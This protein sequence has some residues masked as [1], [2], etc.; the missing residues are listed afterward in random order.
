MNTSRLTG[1]AV[2]ALSLT[3][4]VRT[5]APTVYGLDSAELAAGAYT[6][7]IV[8]SP[9][10]PLFLLIGKLFCFLPWGDVG[11][12]VNLWSAVSAALGVALVYGLAFRLTRKPWISAACALMLAFSYY[13][14]VWALVAE[15]YAPHVLFTAGVLLCLFQWRDTRK[16]AWLWASAA[17]WG[18]GMGNHTALILAAPGMAWLA[19]DN[20]G[21]AW[22]RPRVWGPAVL[23]APAVMFAVY[24]YLP[25]RYAAEPALDYVRAYY[26]DIRLDRPGGFFWMLR[27]GMFSSLFFRRPVWEIAQSAGSFA[28]QIIGNFGFVPACFAGYGAVCM[29]HS[30]TLRAA[31]RGL[32]LIFAVHAF[33][34]W[35]YGAL[36][37]KW[38]YSVC[39]AIWALF[40]AVGWS[41][42][43]TAFTRRTMDWARMLTYAVLALTVIRLGWANYPNVDLSD[44]RSA[45]QAGEE[46][47]AAMTANATCIGAWEHVPILEYLQVVEGLRRDIR[48]VNISLLGRSGA[49]GLAHACLRTGIPL[50]TTVTNALT[51]ETITFETTSAPYLHRV[52]PLAP[53]P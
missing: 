45:R 28:L 35:S 30:R 39:Y 29:F 41:E 11:W 1:L 4:Y 24:L 14:W 12:R 52:Q 50:Y 33:F 3:I 19:V 32:T 44:D 34:Y 37:R 23:A 51:D 16:P 26:P 18:L 36:D 13:Y 53:P 42:A 38:M 21:N 47:M 20:T 46:I 49:H 2:L 22:K 6:L 48:L 10:S 31:A 43:V 7:G 9:G 27:G 8:H 15:L 40:A 17:L 25:I 5:M